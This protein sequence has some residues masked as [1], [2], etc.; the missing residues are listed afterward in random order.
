MCK[1]DAKPLSYTAAKKSVWLLSLS[2]LP[3]IVSSIEPIH[4]EAVKCVYHFIRLVS[5]AK[6][7]TKCVACRVKADRRARDCANILVGIKRRCIMISFFIVFLFFY[8]ENLLSH[9][10]FYSI[11]LFFFSVYCTFGPR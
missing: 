6:K 5:W 9:S 7:N 4:R 10:S 3:P 11:H 1:I 2:F 8:R